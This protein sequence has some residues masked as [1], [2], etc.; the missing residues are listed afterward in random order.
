MFVFGRVGVRWL[1]F[2]VSRL[3]TFLVSGA[4]LEAMHKGMTGIAVWGRCAGSQAADVT[5]GP[6][7]FR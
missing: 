1:G 6:I 7:K 5:C 4:A 3:T 2:G